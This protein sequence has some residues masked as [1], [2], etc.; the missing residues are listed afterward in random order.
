M[1]EHRLHNQEQVSKAERRRETIPPS[2]VSEDHPLPAQ[3][4]RDSRSPI[5]PS[6]DLQLKMEYAKTDHRDGDSAPEQHAL[7]GTLEGL[8]LAMQP[9]SKPVSGTSLP[10]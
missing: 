8:C 4:I 9:G 6:K 3:C 2:L 10:M 1:S 5:L 7:K